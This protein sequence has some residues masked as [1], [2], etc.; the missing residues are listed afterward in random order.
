M[1]L[2]RLSKAAKCLGIRPV[3]PRQWGID[4]KIPFVRI[5]R[6]RRFSSVDVE[7]MKRGSD[8]M[9]LTETRLLG[10]GGRFA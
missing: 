1:D 2:L 4:G 3:T 6:E 10:R 7:H 8:S 9:L 5:G